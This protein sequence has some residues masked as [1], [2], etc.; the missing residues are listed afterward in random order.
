MFLRRRRAKQFD[1]EVQ[2]AAQVSAQP[3]VDDDDY[4]HGSYNTHVSTTQPMSTE[5][6]S[7]YGSSAGYGSGASSWDPYG[8]ATG[9]YEMQ[10]RRTSTGT[11]PG[12]AGF[13]GGD[14]FARAVGVDPPPMPQTY[15]QPQAY[16]Q[17][18][19]GQQAYGQQQ[20]YGDRVYNDRAQAQAGYQTYNNTSP[21][22]SYALAQP[23][24]Q[25]PGR[26][27]VQAQMMLPEGQRQSQNYNTVGAYRSGPS[28]GEAHP[29]EHVEYGHAYGGE[30][31]RQGGYAAAPRASPGTPAAARLSEE[32]PY[33]G[34]LAYDDVGR[35]EAGGSAN[36][37]HTAG[38]PAYV[39]T[40]GSVA[41]TGDRKG[42]VGVAPQRQAS[43]SGQGVSVGRRPSGKSTVT[44][45]SQDVDEDSDGSAYDQAPR[46]VLKVA[47]E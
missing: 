47:N 42:G 44:R 23:A 16:G 10:H 39:S 34:Y 36:Q 37:S 31:S 33:G 27:P 26:V 13:G 9:G 46:R 24:V 4:T 8:R 5:R 19:Y 21:P 22:Q 32:D 25:T 7:G 3:P 41:A 40:A 30:D 18:P 45:Y 17:Q 1:R 38:P 35:D 12:M 28:Y 29:G 15:N 2:E 6:P 20:G 14:S 43:G 11:A